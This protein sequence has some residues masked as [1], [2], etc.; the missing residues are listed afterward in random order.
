M[1]GSVLICDKFEYIYIKHFSLWRGIKDMLYGGN[2]L[3]MKRNMFVTCLNMCIFWKTGNLSRSISWD[4]ELA[5]DF[6]HIIILLIL[7]SYI[8]FQNFKRKFKKSLL[9]QLFVEFLFFAGPCARYNAVC[10]NNITKLMK[11]SLHAMVWMPPLKLMLKF[12]C[13]YNSTGKWGL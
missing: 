11:T 8:L 10:K 5:H 7:T 9:W 2:G 12:N 4:S 3:L 13:R 1:I 6:L